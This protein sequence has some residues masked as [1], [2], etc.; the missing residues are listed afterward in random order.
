MTA[1]GAEMML[2]DLST[3]LTEF[4]TPYPCD[5]SVRPHGDAFAAK[6]QQIPRLRLSTSSV[7]DPTAERLRSNKASANLT[8]ETDESS[9]PVINAAVV[10]YP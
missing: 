3:R 1:L 6:A 8:S 10:W 5:C 9:V 2:H 7:S 4:A